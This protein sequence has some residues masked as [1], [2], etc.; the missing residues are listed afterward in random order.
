MC[1]ILAEYGFTISSSKCTWCT[2]SVSFLG[3]RI[4]SDRWSLVDYLREKR[5]SFPS[6]RCYKDLQ[7][8]IGIISYCRSMLPHLEEQLKE[9]RE[10]LAACKYHREWEEW[11]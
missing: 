4:S 11:W 8:V 9:L 5:D 2:S 7:R 3:Y 1:S 10:R 6:I